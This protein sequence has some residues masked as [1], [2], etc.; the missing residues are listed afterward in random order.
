LFSDTLYD[1]HRLTIGSDVIA[2]EPQC[3]NA[4]EWGCIHTVIPV[5]PI[6][7]WDLLSFRY[8]RLHYENLVQFE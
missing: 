3:G 2:S 6:K 7:D 5:R 1:D 4:V 8:S